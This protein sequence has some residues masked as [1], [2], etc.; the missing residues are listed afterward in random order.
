M[1]QAIAKQDRPVDLLK[2]T[3]NAPSVQEQF[4]NALGEHKDTFVASLIDLYTG[5]RSLQTCKPSVVIAEAL[6]AGDPPPASE[7][8]PRFRYIVVYNNS[9][10]QADGSW[11]KDPYTDVHPRLQ[12]LYPAR[13]ANG[14]VP[15]DQCRCSL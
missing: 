13:H 12:G 4:K 3:I 6:R 2:A 14:A 10:K 15:D 9:V 11:V 7:Q 1:N 8:G 5:D